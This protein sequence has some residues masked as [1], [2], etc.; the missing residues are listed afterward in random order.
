MGQIKVVRD[1]IYPDAQG[2]C[3]QELELEIELETQRNLAL[4]M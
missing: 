3:R 4:I 2:C 1:D